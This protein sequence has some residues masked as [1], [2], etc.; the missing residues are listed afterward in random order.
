MEKMD[1]AVKAMKK[2][3]LVKSVSEKAV[4]MGNLD[5]TDYVLTVLAD[6]VNKKFYKITE[7]K[8]LGKV[9]D[10]FD[11]EIVYFKQFGTKDW[12][13]Y[14]SIYS[15]A[16]FNGME[17]NDFY[18]KTSTFY[19]G[20]AITPTTVKNEIKFT[21]LSYSRFDFNGIF[22]G[23]LNSFKLKN[24]TFEI[25][26]DKT[27]YNLKG[28]KLT[29]VAVN[30]DITESFDFN[31]K[32]ELKLSDINGNFKITAPKGISTAKPAIG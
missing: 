7:D 4:Y 18:E 24:Y 3:K 23:G 32:I 2:F 13:K 30:K 1:K 12:Y 19:A 11:K 31:R 14:F 8:K 10:Y 15:A 5:K 29:L 6:N 16:I 26:I 27:N 20:L 28:I 17:L 22:E 21:G 25:T 9:E